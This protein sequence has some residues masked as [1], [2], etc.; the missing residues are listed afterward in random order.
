MNEKWKF[1]ISA[2]NSIF[3]HQRF[4]KSF[5]MLG[6]FSKDRNNLICLIVL[7]H[8]LLLLGP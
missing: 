1:K 4:R 8:L 5:R 6:D 2:L 3:R 7:K